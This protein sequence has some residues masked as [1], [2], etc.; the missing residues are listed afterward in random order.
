[1]SWYQQP[2][3]W[4]LVGAFIISTIA[5]AI[6]ITQ[7]IL[8]GHPANVLWITSEYLTAILCG[9][10]MHYTYPIIHNSL[11]DWF[12]QPVAIA[13]AA[14]TGGKVFQ[15]AESAILKKYEELIKSSLD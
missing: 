6:S 14:H 7:R 8:K 9:Y 11:P 12:S 15:L 2:D 5:A 3:I 1:M 10:L 13:I 4:G